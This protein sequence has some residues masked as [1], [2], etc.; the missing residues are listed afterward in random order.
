MAALDAMTI[1][2]H[3]RA[4][5][6]LGVVED[7]PE[8]LVVAVVAVSRVIRCGDCGFKTARVHA[9]RRVKVADLAVSGRPT[10]L[11]WHRR[12]FR[13]NN[14]GTTRSEPSPF[15]AGHLTPRL[16]RAVTRD[17][18]HMTVA[19]VARRYG[20][21]WHRVMALVLAEGALL[22]RHR[23]RRPCRVL[24]VD[25]KSMRKGRGQFSTILVDGDRGRVIAVLAGRSAEV[26]GAFLA[27]Q[28]PAWRKGV[29]VVVTD[30]AE[31]YRTAVRKWLPEARHVVDR[32]H[33]VRNFAKVVVSAR[34]DAQRTPPG[35]PHDPALFR[36]RFLLMKRLDRLSGNE[37]ATLGRIFDAHPR[38]GRGVGPGAALPRDLLRPD[39]GAGQPGG[40]RSGGCLHR[41]RRQPRPGHHQ[42]LPLG[43]RVAQL[44]RPASHQR[45]LRGRQ[46][47][48]RGP[49]THG[50]RIPV[51]AQL[52]RPGSHR[53]LRAPARPVAL[54]WRLASS[55]DQFRRLGITGFREEQNRRTRTAVPTPIH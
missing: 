47:Q 24:L 17:V 46:Q 10:T 22:A 3:L 2:L 6:V 1:R 34:R 44:P 8:R 28:S 4:M 43:A 12:R 36:N 55:R 38:A 23:R 5:R 31:C 7:L 42:L 13:C 18:A 27:R 11:V 52:R 45:R 21:S 14:C 25:E 26:L 37:M 53:V 33:V 15:V 29:A 20:L 41:R 49:R 48:D 50:L 32:F 54:M 16:A 51:P 39:R 35:Q 40:R 19:A 30:M 9:T